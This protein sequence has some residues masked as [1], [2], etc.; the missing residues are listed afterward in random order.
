MQQTIL[1]KVWDFLVIYYVTFLVCSAVCEVNRKLRAVGLAIIEFSSA[2]YIL[3]T[4]L[5]E[6]KFYAFVY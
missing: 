5:I 2:Y 4:L 1:I 6:N 3:I